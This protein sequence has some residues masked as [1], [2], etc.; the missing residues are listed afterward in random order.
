M[1]A[2]VVSQRTIVEEADKL[3][4]ADKDARA[5]A[6][7]Q[8]SSF[9]NLTDSL[10]ETHSQFRPQTLLSLLVASRGFKATDPR[11]K[12]FALLNLAA[13]KEEFPTPDFNWT[14]EQ[15]YRRFA[16]LFIRQGQTVDILACAGLQNPALP[17]HSW[18][19][20]WRHVSRFWNLQVNSNFQAG[21][22]T[23]GCIL[24]TA[25]GGLIIPVSKID[26]VKLVCPFDIKEPGLTYKLSK[27]IGDATNSILQERL[28]GLEDKY[29]IEDSLLS[30]LFCDFTGDLQ[31]SNPKTDIANFRARHVLEIMMEKRKFTEIF[32]EDKESRE[33]RERL[34]L[35]T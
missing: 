9:I 22:S 1:P 13:D 8:F 7:E 27:M 24:E 34:G 31:E 15:T 12:V 10:R 25:N 19:P 32:E 28:K 35:P 16:R 5:N 30:L 21:G 29:L 26:C 6:L 33:A 17:K 11:D 23:R 18:V 20:D 2:S 3:T 14:L 4:S